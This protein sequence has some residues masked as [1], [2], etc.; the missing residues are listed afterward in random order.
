MISNGLRWCLKP[1]DFSSTLGTLVVAFEVTLLLV[2]AVDAFVA[3]AEP[4]VV[5]LE[6][7]V[8]ARVVAG[9]AVV[10]WLQ[11]LLGTSIIET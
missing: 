6:V 10:N 5:V 11:K 9:D 4:D 3:G 2:V 1:L 7:I 8:A